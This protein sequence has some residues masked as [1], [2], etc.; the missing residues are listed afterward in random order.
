MKY[1]KTMNKQGLLLTV[2]YQW[3]SCWVN[4]VCRFWCLEAIYGWYWCFCTWLGCSFFGQMKLRQCCTYLH[5]KSISKTCEQLLLKRLQFERKNIDFIVSVF[6]S[7]VMLPWPKIWSNS[8]S[9]FRVEPLL[10]ILN[11][12][13]S[14]IRCEYKT[15]DYFRKLAA[16]LM[17]NFL[18][19][20]LPVMYSNGEFDVAFGAGIS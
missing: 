5:W 20:R 4:Y 2:I 14:Y 15:F 6:F 13:N 12:G 8:L 1:F 16:R 7:L 18:G 19:G 11:G 17:N 3:F 10:V 9:D